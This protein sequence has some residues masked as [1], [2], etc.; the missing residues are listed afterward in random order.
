VPGLG[1][2]GDDQ[3]GADPSAVRV[4]SV[5]GFADGDDELGT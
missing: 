2:A 1:C 3:L 4:S 5:K